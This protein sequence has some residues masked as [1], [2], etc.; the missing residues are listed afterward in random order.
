M[1][2]VHAAHFIELSQLADGSLPTEFRLFNFGK[3]ETSK[4]TFVLD[5]KGAAA[6][7]AAYV[8]QGVDLAIDYEHQTFAAIDNGKPAPAAGWFAP[9]VRSDGVWAVNVRWTDTAASMLRG[10]EYRYHSPT[11][12]ADEDDRITR[13]LPLALT[14]FP[15]TKNQAP[16][17]AARDAAAMEKFMP[18]N[19]IIGLKDAADEG[20]VEARIVSLAR[21]EGE[22]L[23]V[24]GAENV[25]DALATVIAQKDTAVKL[26]AAEKSLREWQEADERTKQIERE[27]EIAGVIDQ[28]VLDGR[29]SLKD[30]EKIATLKSLGEVH[31]VSALKTAVGLMNARP[32]RVYHAPVVEGTEESRMKAI[33]DYQRSHPDMSFQ[34]AY[35]ALAAER[36]SLFDGGR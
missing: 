23:K 32:V 35:V 12:H 20:E 8:D 17:I 18:V 29:V 14:N 10:K 24:T 30:S 33:R 15:A 6:I 16:L 7:M 5:E 13:L 9:E 27:R 28:A 3:N 31:G 26:A 2:V 22:L 21:T 36:P 19:K 4:G 25:G 34:D 1:R 11:F